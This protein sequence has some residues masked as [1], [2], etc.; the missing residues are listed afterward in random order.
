MRRTMRF[1]LGLLLVLLSISDAALS[2]LVEPTPIQPLL[3]YQGR[4]TDASGNPLEGFVTLE[5]TIEQES[6]FGYDLYSAVWQNTL[7]DVPLNDGFFSVNLGENEPLPTTLAG[8]DLRLLLSV[9]GYPEFDTEFR[10]TWASQAIF[11]LNARQLN[12]QD[13]SAYDQRPHV[14][15]LQNPHGVSAAQIGAVTAAEF[16]TEVN[17]LNDAIATKAD[18]EHA[19]DDR[20]YTETE[21]DELLA[22]MTARIDQLEQELQALADASPDPSFGGAIRRDGNELIFEG[23][24]VSIRNGSGLTD[25]SN[26]LGNLLLG[27]NVPKDSTN[28][29]HFRGGSHNLIIGDKHR[30]RSHAGLALGRNSVIGSPHA[31][32]IGSSHYAYGTYA[33]ALGGAANNP[34]TDRSIVI[35]GGGNSASGL[36]SIVVGGNSNSTGADGGLIIGGRSNDVDSNGTSAII[37]GGRDNKVNGTGAIVVGGTGNRNDVPTS[38]IVGRSHQVT[39]G[40]Q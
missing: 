7:V 33:I 26:G 19:H 24:N 10:M 5:F 15:N 28:P 34:D 37:V 32:A 22:A 29:T 6:A 20:Y 31:V 36:N 16:Q 38:L 30:Y 9:D 35:G 2:Q 4:L 39:G 18:L 1:E 23:V 12:G 40:V 21:V 14:N 11:S 8:T 25:S 27:Y 13:A 17:L 3:N